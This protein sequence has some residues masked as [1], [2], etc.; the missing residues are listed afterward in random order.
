MTNIII[1]Y[2][3]RMDLMTNTI[4]LYLHVCIPNNP[5][6]YYIYNYVPITD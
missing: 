1:L 4:I 2:L 6:N 5:H 3:F